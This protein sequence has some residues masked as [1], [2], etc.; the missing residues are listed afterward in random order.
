MGAVNDLIEAS[1]WH[2]HP[3]RTVFST[4]VI[5]GVIALIGVAAPILLA[6]PHWAG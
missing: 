5:L 3:K 1:H 2:H 6:F 4:V